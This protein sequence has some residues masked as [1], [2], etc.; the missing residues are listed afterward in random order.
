MIR[1]THYPAPPKIPTRQSAQRV[2]ILLMIGAALTF[3]MQDGLSRLLAES[4]NVLTVVGLRYW[5]FA[6]FVLAYSAGNAKRTGGI[7]KVARTRRPVLQFSRGVLLVTEICT[8]VWGFTIVGLVG[9]QVIFAS[10]PLMI[11]A[12]SVPILGER[13]G[14]RRWLA[15]AA[16]FIGVGIALE[17]QGSIFSLHIILPVAGALQF[18]AYNI[19]TRLAGRTE[20]ADTS[21]F[22]TGVVGALFITLLMPFNWNPPMGLDWG[23]MLLLCVTGVTGHFLIIKALQMA[24]A[25]V[26]QPFAY[27]GVLT[28]AV[29]G[30]VFFDDVVTRSMIIGGTLV[31]GAGMFTFWREYV[32]AY[33]P[34]MK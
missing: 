16:G 29:V 27:F 15:I 5:F 13:V 34:E 3:G 22:W 4:Y 2:G 6:A 23:W 31:I 10:Y 12:M 20:K 1:H 33:A 24:E 11:A 18:A 14:W 7:V 28:S 21:F 32:R 30:Y 17:P 26:L 9:W 8:A 25:G 19:L